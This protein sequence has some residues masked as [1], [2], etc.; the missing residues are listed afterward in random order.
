VAKALSSLQIIARVRGVFARHWMDL[1]LITIVFS[2]GTV[3]LQGRAQKLQQAGEPV[4]EGL[5]NIIDQEIKRVKGVKR[6]HFNFEN[7]VK[8]SSGWEKV[9]ER[10]A[11][12]AA[13]GGGGAYTLDGTQEEEEGAEERL[14]EEQED[15][16]ETASPSG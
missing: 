12:M 9:K 11:V 15:A 8:T 3:R 2:N 16:G 5:L 14:P 1:G 4:D 6:V 13:G 7:W 10:R